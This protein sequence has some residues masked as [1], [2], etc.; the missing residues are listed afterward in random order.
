MN[1]LQNLRKKLMLGVRKVVEKTPF[2][3]HTG[4]SAGLII[5]AT[6]DYEIWLILQN[7]LYLAQPGTLVEFGSGRS[8]Y[9]LAEYALKS[10]ARVLSVE[11]H[12]SYCLRVN[13]GLKLSFLP[14][15]VVKYVPI[16]GDW[17]DINKVRRYLL[18]LGGIDFLF[19]DGPTG[20]SRGKRNSKSFYDCVVPYLRDIKIAVID[21]VQKKE[22]NDMAKYLV[23]NLKLRRYDI[24]Y[25]R[26]SILAFLVNSDVSERVSDLP[27]YLREL[28]IPVE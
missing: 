14:S 10:S 21:D 6:K 22:C 3:L 24:K 13:G 11:Q 19:V 15:G 9:Y 5:W 20:F 12:L 8:T 18:E 1:F 23:R 28:L 27:E 7:L 2:L 25:S 17:Y 4:H 16:R 26:N